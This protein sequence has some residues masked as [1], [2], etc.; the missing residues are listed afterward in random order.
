MHM[1]ALHWSSLRKR[2]QLPNPRTEKGFI[3]PTGHGHGAE[4][5]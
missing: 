5:T 4:A 2:Q 3:Q 1:V